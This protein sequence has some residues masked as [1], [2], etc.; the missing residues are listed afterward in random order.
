[1]IVDCASD[2][3]RFTSSRLYLLESPI[4]V[5]WNTLSL[6]MV[7]PSPKN[8]DPLVPSPD[9]SHDA[10]ITKVLVMREILSRIA[11]LSLLIVSAS[12]SNAGHNE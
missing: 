8:S 10:T 5:S 11:A 2:F 7:I 1:V 3:V 6:M 4:N 12:I 9:S